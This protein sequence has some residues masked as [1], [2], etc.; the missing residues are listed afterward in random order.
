MKGGKKVTKSNTYKLTP[1][2]RRLLEALINPDNLDKNVTQ[3][4]N[5]ADISRNSYYRFMKE[6]E[7]VDLVND[8]IMDL[9]K[10]KVG[11]IMNATYKF[12]LTEKGHQDRKM[13][14]TMLGAYTEKKEISMNGKL[15]LK[16]KGERFRKYLK[17]ELEATNKE[18]E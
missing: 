9:I 11:N 14:L 6:Q 5:I 10:G 8:T 18:S 7:F 13:L 2:S 3:L 1:S 15:S 17:E 12:A 16:E 4:C